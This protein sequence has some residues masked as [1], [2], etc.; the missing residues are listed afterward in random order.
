MEVESGQSENKATSSGRISSNVFA[1]NPNHVLDAIFSPRNVALIGA[2]DKA[3]SIGR[4]LLWNLIS[5]PFGGTI[6][7]VNANRS[8]VLG[9]K[10]YPNVAALPER[11]DLAVIATPA[12]TVPG[13]I[14]ECV[15]AGIKGAVIVSA[16]F[17]E[18]GAAGAE[19]EQRILHEARK[20]G[21]RVVGPN[22]LG[23]MRPANG[24]NATISPEMA[25]PGSV[26]F[27]SQS[28]ALCSAV[29]D[30]S[31]RENVGF[32]AFISVGGMVDVG[33]GDLIDYLGDDPYTKSIVI[34]METI[35]DA[36][37]FLSAAREVALSKPIILINTGRTQAAA[38]AAASHTGAL[39]GS[40]E[41]FEAAFRR[42]GV[43]S[44]NSI[45]ELFY[46]AEVLA[47]QPRPK[48]PRLTIL[49][50]AGG[51][52]VLATETLTL[53]GGELAPLSDDS[54]A[55][56]DKILPPYWSKRNPIDILGDADPARFA[57]AFEI[58]A[59]DPTTDGLLVILAPQ[60][61]TNPTETAVQLKKYA[62]LPG[63]PVL[64][65]WMG[66]AEVA[67]GDTILN[68]AGIPTFPYPEVAAQIF[69]YMWRYNFNL[70]GL[71]ETPVL[72]ADADNENSSRTQA[73][74][75]IETAR[76]TGRTRLSEYESKQ[77]LKI[78]G[79]PTVATQVAPTE[80]QAV[81][82]AQQFGYPV[83]LKLYSHLI[84]H[85]S[86]IGGVHLDLREEAEVRTAFRAIEVTMREHAAAEAFMGVAV[87]PM[88]RAD[89][90]ELI[91]GSS[92]DPQF[93]PVLLF[94]SGGQL[95]EVYQDRALG[96]PPLNTTL[97]RRMIEQTRISK[98]LKGIRGRPPVNLAAL[99]QLMVRFSQLV[100]E[101]RWIK[102]LDIN[103]L[104]ASSTQL[105]ALDARVVLHEP[106][107]TREQ[108]PRLAIRPY[109]AQ[110][111]KNWTM[112][113][114]VPV[115]IR[116]IRPE[117]EPLMVKFHETLSER[118][119]YFRWLHLLQLS[120]RVAHERL[121]RIC[122]ID[123]DREIALV[124]DCRDSETGQHQILGVSR[125]S[126]LRGANNE[127]EFAVLVNDQFQKRGIGTEL[128]KELIAVG[129]AEKIS[130]LVGDIHPENM[131]MQQVCRKLGFKLHYSFD[132]QLTKAE[133]NL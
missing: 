102:E 48:G 131:G 88:I 117:D 65:S 25:R 77:I 125:L 96:L 24:L 16:G 27:V 132:E 66:G 81:Q 80:D 28:G 1:Y 9:I 4:T 30:W 116:P 8:N 68:Q 22:C 11:A 87:Q 122:F 89:G 112:Q 64:A 98:A 47:K 43:I 2:T 17:K 40:Y 19:L 70:K 35:G 36:R 13:V 31:L 37:S 79:I 127:A 57:A 63:K 72:L 38:L 29:L 41:V 34:Y 39:T 6:F 101:Q 105:I 44:V 74:K 73:M 84:T 56:F 111:I 3:G 10:A 71:Y 92:L 59:K 67:T 121:I 123:Y 107:V 113:T 129:R 109:P 93:G 114:D 104:L 15:A 54:R 52:G 100:A 110:Y 95:V 20:G 21:L 78:Y 90:Y 58:A 46:L 42:S 83:V 99:E 5:N 103:P 18:A 133:L 12:A 62:N 50:N 60:A 118:S 120:A 91:L 86:D 94:G 82:L 108:L 51:P 76:S 33:W 69:N 23:I 128:L 55:A 45:G 26:G 53:G 106:D 119:V 7:P 32:S 85:K 49:T 14:A 75:L 61:A 115:V 126:K 97:A 130:R 124:A